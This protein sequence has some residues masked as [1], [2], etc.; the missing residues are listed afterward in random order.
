MQL[1]ESLLLCMEVNFTHS[2]IGEDKH[3]RIY[4]PLTVRCANREDVCKMDIPLECKGIYF[5]ICFPSLFHISSF[6]DIY[7]HH[8][9]E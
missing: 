9:L 6:L 8:S 2:S 1:T 3:P 7:F 5:I 4:Y